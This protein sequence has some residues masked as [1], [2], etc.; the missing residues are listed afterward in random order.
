MQHRRLYLFI[1]NLKPDRTDF[2][3]P[4]APMDIVGVV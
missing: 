2:S 3:K 1:S 4:K